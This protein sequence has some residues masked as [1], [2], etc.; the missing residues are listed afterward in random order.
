MTTT[1]RM[2][3][4]RFEPML[5][6]VAAANLERGQELL[7]L[8][9]QLGFR[10]SGLVVTQSH[11][12]VAICSYSLA[13]TILLFA[14]SGPLQVLPEYRAA[15]KKPMPDWRQIFLEYNNYTMHSKTNFYNNNTRMIQ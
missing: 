5:L 14:Y 4:L 13:L 3:S 11:V 7:Q 6:H 10:E 2:M 15:Y 9:L 12:M 1:R 8:V